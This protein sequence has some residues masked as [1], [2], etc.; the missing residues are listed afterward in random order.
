[1]KKISLTLSLLLLSSGI[2]SAKTWNETAITVGKNKFDNPEML[3]SYN[4]FYGIRTTVYD[5]KYYENGYGLQFGY[6]LG[7][8]SNCKDL[9]LSRIYTNLVINAPSLE[10]LT[11]YALI[12]AGYE[13][14]NKE[15]FTPSQGYLSAG[16]GAKYTFKNNLFAFIESRIINK[17]DSDNTDYISTMGLGYKFDV[18]PSMLGIYA[19]VESI[20]PS[21]L[22]IENS[23]NKTASKRVSSTYETIYIDEPVH[24]KHKK[25]KHK[26]YSKKGG[27]YFV[28]LALYSVTNPK[29]LLD[30]LD[31]KGFEAV[32]KKSS[33]GT[34]ILA[35]P[36]KNRAD[37]QRH[38]G[39]LKYIKKD[40]YI[41][42]R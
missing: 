35:G 6:E 24:K 37:A 16:I 30:L 39:K 25:I 11:P 13:I 4:N 5:D 28:Q 22:P 36:Y 34:L 29:P 7:R 40:A 31:R 12:G 19:P 33:N 18:T 42:K 41:V 38:L 26:S 14:S 20:T 27:K 32:T 15:I 23:T 9:D 10:G 3:K 8:D 21:L 1:M 17:L 2:L